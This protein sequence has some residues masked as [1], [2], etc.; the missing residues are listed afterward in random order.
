MLQGIGVHD[1]AQGATPSPRITGVV[2]RSVV[3]QVGSLW[4]SLIRPAAYGAGSTTL[5][6]KRDLLATADRSG[7]E[8]TF[9]HSSQGDHPSIIEGMRARPYCPATGIGG[10]YRCADGPEVAQ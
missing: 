2:A 7:R 5:A 1:T 3:S 9:P 4:G 10:G 8:A 6:C